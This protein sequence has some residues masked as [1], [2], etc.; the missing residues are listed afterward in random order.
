M[1]LV[2]SLLLLSPLAF[3]GGK[4]GGSIMDLAFPAFNFVLLAT[5]LV[6]KLKKPLNDGFKKQAQDTKD[7]YEMADKKDKEAQIR[8]EALQQ[9]MSNLDQEKKKVLDDTN[10]QVEKVSKKVEQDADDYLDRVRRDFQSKL[11]NE[12]KALYNQINSE[13][14]NKIVGEAKSAISGN[15]DYT[16]KATQKLLGKIG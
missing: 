11:K 13:L 12:E 8:L 2:I 7:L 15:L 3:A 6:I 4:G 1:K 5:F 14:I 9:K 16:K 10:K